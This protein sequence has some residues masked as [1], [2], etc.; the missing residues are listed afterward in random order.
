MILGEI[1]DKYGQVVRF[2]PHKLSST[3]LAAIG[4]I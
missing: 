1:H 4:V 3:D 2:G